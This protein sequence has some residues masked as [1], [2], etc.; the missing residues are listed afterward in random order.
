MQSLAGFRGQLV[1]EFEFLVALQSRDQVLP[2]RPVRLR[3][4]VRRTSR[5]FVRGARLLMATSHRDFRR[6]LFRAV[7]AESN[8]SSAPDKI[9]RMAE[10]AASKHETMLF[11]AANGVRVDPASEYTEALNRLLWYLPPKSRFERMAS[12]E[13]A[14]H[15]G[16]FPGGTD[17]KNLETI[18]AIEVLSL[19]R[20]DFDS[21]E[22]CIREKLFPAH[23]MP[24]KQARRV[25]A[26]VYR[27][28]GRSE[29][30][31]R[32]A[33]PPWTSL[34]KRNP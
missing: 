11:E 1:A 2:R 9:V 17:N 32:K 5:R 20:Y 4:R 25:M 24:Q 28:Q 18:E 3:N 15:P 16:L 31:S 27:A 21:D 22:E 26:N 8:L 33:S 10:A 13:P 7:F 30:K 12:C 34:P 23:E 19:Y 29:S 14:N 6:E